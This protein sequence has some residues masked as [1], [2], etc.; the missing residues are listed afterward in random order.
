MTA[1]RLTSPTILLLGLL[2]LAACSPMANVSNRPTPTVY[3]APATPAVYVPP[4]PPGSS[5]HSQPTTVLLLGIDRRKAAGG[6]SN[7]DTLLLLHLN[8][9]S[10]RIAML[11]IPRDLYVEIPDHGQGRINTAYSYGKRDGTGGLALAR[12]TVSNA[13]GVPVDHVILIDFEVFVTI[14]DAIGGVDVDVPYDIYDPTYPDSGIGYDPFYL[15]AGQQHLDGATALKYARTRA[16]AG[17]DFDRTARQ[18]QIVLAVRDQVLNL[19]M[20]PDLITQSPQ[21][22]ASLQGAFETDLTLSEIIDLVLTASKAPTDEVATGA[23]DESCTQS[24]VTPSGAQVLVPLQD[25]IDA[26]VNE[27]FSSPP[28]SASTQ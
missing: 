10:Q 23:I 14:I 26:V 12:Q 2:A 21:L 1:R 24:W 9:T 19:N 5:A 17:G 6:T 4:L 27:L 16:T 18:R 20:L 15:P 7:T 28:A 3:Y 22:W 25:K 8:P 13:I 11:S